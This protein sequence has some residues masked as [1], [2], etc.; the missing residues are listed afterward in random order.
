MSYN[1][2]TFPVNKFKKEMIFYIYQI[3]IFNFAK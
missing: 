2:L 3:K 1:K